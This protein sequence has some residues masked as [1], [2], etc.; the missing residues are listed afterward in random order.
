MNADSRTNNPSPDSSTAGHGHYR[1]TICALLFFSVAVNYIDRMTLGILKGPLSEKLGW[2]DLDYGYIT[3]AFSFAYAFGYLFGGWAIEKLGVRRGLPLFVI[4]WSAAAMAH[5]FCGY[6]DLNE[7]FRMSY[8]WY[9]KVENGFALMTLIMPLT[10]AGFMFARVILGLSEGANFP[11]AI[12]IVAEWFPVKERA[13]ATGLFNAGTNVGAILC[14]VGV[15]WIFKHIGWEATFYVTG[16]TGFLWVILWWFVYDQ[17]D[18]H[19]RLSKEE[20]A[21]IRAGQPAAEEKK[22]K[23]P[24]ITLLSYRAVWAYVIA[25]ILAAPAWGFYQ[26]FLPDFLAKRFA[27]PAIRVSD[28]TNAD[29]FVAKLKQGSDRISLHIR[30]QLSSQTLELLMNHQSGS[31]VKALNTALVGDLN[32]RITNGIS[33]DPALFSSIQL[34]PETRELLSKPANTNMTARINRMLLEDT[35]PNE[36]SH[37]MNLQVIGWWTGGFFA[38]AAIGGVLGGWLAGRLMNRGWSVNN[39]R[40]LSFLICALAVVPVFLAPYAESALVAVLIIGIAGS[41]HQGWSANLFSFVSD[42]MPKQSISSVVGLGG[43]VGYFA[44]GFVNAFT[45][46]I[47][48]KTGSYVLVFLYFSGTYLV[49]LL[50]MQLL[51]PKIGQSKQTAQT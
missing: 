12:K 16:A 43:F 15:P 51:V 41:A 20:L 9:S 39:A 2:T 46:M 26:S 22:V 11:A 23:I 36:L 32:T 34:R 14:P 35:Y 33:F 31:D 13:L 5:G 7:Q 19:R 38:L 30:N 44:G 40:K 24:W 3:A 37:M 6:L 10:A 45:G 47:V 50:A 8:P 29:A 21:Y 49:S 27:A 42:T 4:I 18:K 25:G 17:P 1:W 28:V 48:Q